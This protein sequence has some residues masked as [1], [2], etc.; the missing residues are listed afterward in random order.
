MGESE[1]TTMM[2]N[3]ESEREIEIECCAPDQKLPGGR[4]ST[5]QT[6]FKLICTTNSELGII[7]RFVPQ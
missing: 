5:P 7:Y 2:C 6:F 1:T 4:I 3:R